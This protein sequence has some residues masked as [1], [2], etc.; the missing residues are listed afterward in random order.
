MSRSNSPLALS[1]V[2]IT[3]VGDID[4]TASEIMGFDQQD[5]GFNH[6]Q[7]WS[8]MPAALRGVFVGA[9]VL[10]SFKKTPVRVQSCISALCDLGK[11]EPRETKKFSDYPSAGLKNAAFI[12]WDPEIKVRVKASCWYVDAGQTIIPILQPRKAAL[13]LERLAV[14]HRLATQAYCQGDWIDASIQLIDLSGEGKSAVA[15]YLPTSMLPEVSDDLVARYVNTFV[16]AKK[17]A[18]IQREKTPKK[19]KPIPMEE[20]LDLTS[21]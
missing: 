4:A 5:F 20:L 16:E 6:N 21:R 8:S 1:V 15:R 18:D 11:K 7:T 3:H 2:S 17:I 12:D 14:Y 13:S 10:K 19:V 9:E